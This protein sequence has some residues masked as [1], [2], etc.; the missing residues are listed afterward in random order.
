MEH[1]AALYQGELSELDG[2]LSP[3]LEAAG[4]DAIVLVTSDHGESFSHG[5]W[6]NHRAGLW[7]EITRVPLIL[8]G[9]GVP[10][11]AVIDGQVGLI[12]VAPTLLSLAGLPRDRRMAGRDLS[13][14]FVGQGGSRAVVYSTTDPAF[15]EPQLA[16]RTGDG[17]TILRTAGALVYDLAVDPG[18][19]EALSAER[20]D[21]AALRAAYAATLSPFDAARVAAPVPPPIDPEEAARLEALGYLVPG[22]PPGPPPGQVPQERPP[23]EDEAPS[24]PPR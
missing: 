21:E 9:P 15:P 24:Q 7:D 18:E 13:P 3:V 23:R 8:R 4:P 1:I 14:M 10:V 22:G 19:S 11:G 2:H 12:D 16:V 20:V 17:K 6:F 5:Y